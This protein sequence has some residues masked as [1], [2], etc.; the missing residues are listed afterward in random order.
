[1]PVAAAIALLDLAVAA[2]LLSAVHPA[3]PAPAAAAAERCSPANCQA[4]NR[5]A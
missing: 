1:M 3:A 2:Q 5:L 4:R